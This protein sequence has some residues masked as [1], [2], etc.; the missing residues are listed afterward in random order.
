ML[1]QSDLGTSL[2]LGTWLLSLACS[3]SL[4]FASLKPAP[5]R[6]VV[7]LDGS[8]QVEQGSMDSRPQAFSHT[9]PVPGLMDMA[10]PAFKEIGKKS[11]LRQAFWYR[12]TFRLD[13]AIPD[14]AILKIHKAR[15]G[16]KVFVNDKIA[17]EHLPCFTPA[18]IDVRELLKSGGQENELVIRIGADDVFAAGANQRPSDSQGPEARKSS[19]VEPVV[20]SKERAAFL[21]GV[22]A[23]HEVGQ[24]AAGPGVAL[25]SAAG[26][27]GS[28]GPAGTFPNGLVQ[29]PIDH[30][31]SIVEE[32]VKEGFVPAG[33]SH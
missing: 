24:N 20:E 4:A 15:Y 19:S 29:I 23:D 8:W 27:V 7:N 14:V 2:R 12:R 32:R 10:Q 1:I 3:A 31:P 6:T 26:G 25:P 13:G 5:P 17:G 18:Y 30:N 28:E 16:T 9:V 21:Q 11:P 33:T 22:R